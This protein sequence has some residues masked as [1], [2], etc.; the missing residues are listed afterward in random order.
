MR[1]PD[2]LVVGAGLA[3][4]TAGCLLAR[5]GQRVLIIAQG[6]GA[7]LL[8]S[9]TID[10]LGFH[11][12]E[13][14]T[15]VSNPLA[16]FDSFVA[17]R[18]AHPYA[19][20]GQ[21]RLRAGLE[22]FL[23]LV[24]HS[25]LKYQGTPDHN[26]LLPSGA[27]AVHPTCLAPASLA[28]GDLS[29]V[30]RALI[31]GFREFRDFYPGLISDNLNEQE[32]GVQCHAIVIGLPAPAT[33][34]MNITPIQ[35]AGAFE[36]A[37]F[38]SDLAASIARKARGADRIGFPAVL[39]LAAHAEAVADLE[40]RLD[41]PVFEISCLPPS[42]PGRRLFDVLKHTFH[43]AGGQL[44]VSSQVVD[45]SIQD[46]RVTQL[47]FATV[48]R[49]RSVRARHYLLATGGIF[50][51]GIQTDADGR[52]WDPILNLPVVTPDVGL[53]PANL[54]GGDVAALQTD[55]RTWFV[56]RF[57]ASAGQ[58]ITYAGVPVD[59]HFHP[60]D[61]TGAPLAENL[62]VAGASLAGSNWISGRTGNGLAVTTAA[63]IAEE[64]MSK[65]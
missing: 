28:A 41:R 61:S 59:G 45:G 31:V 38:R 55:R 54:I 44:I 49:L 12:P 25:E 13:A 48:N 22:T 1:Q 11:P 47:R 23:D 63:A 27:G 9:G 29:R 3:G 46:G 32:L 5:A 40:R 62:Y 57:L 6:M 58:P 8:S 51:G 16:A 53:T 64:I 17:D 14:Q 21:E 20:L 36:D 26:W 30:G 37:D 35:L 65:E 2:T 10:V 39:G 19:C 33:G 52:V 18:P 43:A 24:D 7:L 60:V 42:A 34:R 15:P 50:G 56:S 4:L